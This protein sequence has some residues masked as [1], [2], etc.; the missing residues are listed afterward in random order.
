MNFEQA[1]NRIKSYV[2]EVD[3]DRL[4]KTSF[5]VRLKRKWLERYNKE[6]EVDP[7]QEFLM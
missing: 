7:K 5:N 6:Y 4:M 2:E 3:G 1:M